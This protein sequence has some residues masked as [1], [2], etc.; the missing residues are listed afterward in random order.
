M[1]SAARV[2]EPNDESA[3]AGGGADLF[4]EA[5]LSVLGEL[6]AAGRDGPTRQG[7]SRKQDIRA[8]REGSLGGRDDTRRGRGV[9][10]ANYDARRL[11]VL[12]GRIEGEGVLADRKSVV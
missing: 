4:R 3:L 8:R 9:V 6:L 10:E 7:R 12:T 5:I 11:R 2:R 1:D